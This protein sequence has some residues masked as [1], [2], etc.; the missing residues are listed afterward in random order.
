M[1]AAALGPA[2]SGPVGTALAIATLAGPI[3]AVPM[4]AAVGPARCGPVRTALGVAG[5]ITAV[6]R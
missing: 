1:T 3:T 6:D 5:P 4:T 2:R